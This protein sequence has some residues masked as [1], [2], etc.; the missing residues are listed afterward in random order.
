MTPGMARP[1]PTPAE[2]ITWPEDLSE[3]IEKL[4][5][6][7]GMDRHSLIYTA[8]EEKIERLERERDLKD[9]YISNAPMILGDAH[10]EPK[11]FPVEL[12]NLCNDFLRQSMVFACKFV[13]VAG[14]PKES[15][16]EIE[17]V[18]PAWCSEVIAKARLSVLETV[19][20]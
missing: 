4:A 6:L 10:Q 11:T 2:N 3:R 8:V 17:S 15:A 20:P 1:A 16:S 5:I 19:Q 18:I 13:Q 12:E 9:E 14:L 7:L